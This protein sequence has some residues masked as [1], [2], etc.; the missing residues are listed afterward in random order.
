V[1]PSCTSDILGGG[2]DDTYPFHQAGDVR[3]VFKRVATIE[4]SM[5]GLNA[6]P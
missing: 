5:P 1:A 4:S 6:S 2:P 3:V